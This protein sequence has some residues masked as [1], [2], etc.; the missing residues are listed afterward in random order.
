M[1]SEPTEQI[2]ELFNRVRASS[3]EIK[4]LPWRSRI[5]KLRRLYETILAMQPEIRQAVWQ[6]FKKPNAEV[7]IS[8][9]YPVTSAIKFAIR[10]LKRWSD[11]HRVPRSLA[12]APA[13][14]YI[15]YEPKGTVLII[16]PWNYPFMLAL[17]PLVSA[18]A[19][20][21]AIILKPSELT[22]YTSSV[23]KK[24]V[25]SVFDA[26]EVSVVEGGPEHSTALLK[27]PFDHIF[28]TG[29]PRVGKIVMS[30]ASRHLSGI[31]LEL[32]G[33]SP[34][35]V[36]NNADVQ[37]AASRLIAGKCT[38]A[39]QTC[40]APDYVL[41]HESAHDA[42]VEKMAQEIR[43]R[44]GTEEQQQATPDFARI[45]ND[46][47]YRRISGLID[48][49]LAAGARVFTGN[50]RN[51]TERYLSPTIL[52][53]VDT[54]MDIMLD[55]IFG[56]VL[57]VIPFKDETEALKIIQSLPKPLALYIFTSQQRQAD[58]FIRKTTAGTTCI[59]DAVI[60]F[61]HHHLPFGGVNNSGLGSAHGFF[62]F[63]SFSHERGVFVN[64]WK[65][66]AADLL[67]PPYGDRIRWLI[68][69]TIKWF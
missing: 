31:T 11:K 60:H 61:L 8:E 55:E 9:I 30:A 25:E 23:I 3:F 5:E 26:S 37:Y 32:G 62:G 57:P 67:R 42:L 10:N 53:K 4:T 69:Q 20:G 43:F 64:K 24:I 36:F 22:P 52:T 7:D 17:S 21:N 29:S 15:T 18:V 34:A 63:K 39:G 41:V 6:D 38:N 1:N 13:S 51:D 19:A 28:F 49:A 35:V 16:A 45:I 65:F 66:T 2:Q 46:G 59:N 48:Q 56:P 33:K 50:R 58:E 14:A 44:Y 68:D 12:L 47:H 54:G 27:L 40:L